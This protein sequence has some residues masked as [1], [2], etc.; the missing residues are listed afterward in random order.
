M[1]NIQRYWGYS[2]G[3]DIGANGSKGELS[4]GWTTNMKVTLRSFS[5]HHVD[6]EVYEESSDIKWRLTGFYGHPEGRHQLSLEFSSETGVED[7]LDLLVSEEPKD[8]TLLELTDI[9][10]QLNLEADKE[11]R[12]WKQ[13]ARINWLKYRDHNSKFFHGSTTAKRKFNLIKGLMNDIGEWVEDEK[14]IEATISGYFKNVFTTSDKDNSTVIFENVRMSIT[15]DMNE[16]LLQVF[17]MEEIRV[18]VKDM[19]PLKAFGL[20]GFPTLS[21]IRMFE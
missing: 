1:E 16:K 3:I 5:N 15:N 2:H 4:L 14:G 6:V 8:D 12:Y 10:L 9:R 13:H 7:T 20:D 21:Q 11:E 19:V 18:A 17:T